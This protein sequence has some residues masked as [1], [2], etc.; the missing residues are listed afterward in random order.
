MML[1]IEQVSILVLFNAVNCG[2][3]LP[4]KNGFIRNRIHTREGAIIEY[5]CDDGFRPSAN[6]FSTCDVDASWIRS[7]Q[8]LQCTFVKGSHI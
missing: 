3:P 5:G 8:K 7:P 2:E 1:F 6:F 4:P